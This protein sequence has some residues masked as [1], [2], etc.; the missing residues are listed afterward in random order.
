M[1][2]TGVAILIYVSADTFLS[3]KTNPDIVKPVAQENILNVDYRSGESFDRDAFIENRMG[4]D[5]KSLMAS[6]MEEERLLKKEQTAPKEKIEKIANIPVISQAEDVLQRNESDDEEPEISVKTFATLKDEKKPEITKAANA[7][8]KTSPPKLSE[9]LEFPVSP[10][11]TKS[12]ESVPDEIVEKK[13]EKVILNV[14]V[15]KVFMGSVTDIRSEPHIEYLTVTIDDQEWM[16]ENLKFDPE[17]HD[18]WKGS[19]YCFKDNPDNCNIFGGVYTWDTVMNH[20]TDEGIQG[21]CMEGWHVP[22]SEEWKTLRNNVELLS[23][24]SV[25][26]DLMLAGTCVGNGP[27]GTSGFNLQITGK[28]FAVGIWKEDAAYFWTSTSSDRSG[29]AYGYSVDDSSF[30]LRDSTHGSGFSVRC[31]RGKI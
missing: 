3:S 7:I 12:T 6:A 13:I 30:V 4:I 29:K 20:Q 25:N 16:A 19:R 10:E 8:K 1:I 2:F 14:K 27:C 18:D 9:V 31:I 28:R 5:L 11:P 23:D 26:R 17:T 24:A 21:I 22:T 15:P